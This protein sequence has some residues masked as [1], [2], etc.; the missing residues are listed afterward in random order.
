MKFRVLGPL[1][2]VDHG[3]V[4]QLPSGKAKLLLAALLVDAGHVVSTDRLYEV[5]WGA[6][7]P[8]TASNTLQTY[9]N[10]LRNALE[11]GRARRQPSR[12][13]LMK[14]PGYVLAAAP[15]DIDA[16]RF[17]RLVSEGRRRLHEP[18]EA[19]ATLRQA[20]DL[21]RGEALADF[22]F[23]PFAQAEITRLSEL[24]LAVLEDRIRADLAL[25]GHAQLCGELAQLVARHPLR[26]Q[27]WGHLMVA[28]Y[29]CGRQAEA[30]RAFTQLRET[31]G[32]QL[33]I[34]PSPALAR[35]EEAMLLQKPELD[36]PPAPPVS[37][38]AAY[39]DAV[40]LDQP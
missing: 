16:G 13:V 10:H 12:F 22:T 18:R 28:L 36:W 40:T 1:E 2:V 9:V 20:L 24:R 38:A 8:D 11:P 33:G 15:E 6:E 26:E 29:R 34:S 7:P 4:V 19:A 31:L 17:E 14:A 3:A 32:E 37:S 35:L 23:E 30:L 5:L 39:R 25:G 27:L 21:W